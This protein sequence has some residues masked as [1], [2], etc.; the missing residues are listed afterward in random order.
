MYP[1][2]LSNVRYFF[3]VSGTSDISHFYDTSGGQTNCCHVYLLLLIFTYCFILLLF[4]LTALTALIVTYCYLLY[5]GQTHCT[6]SDVSH[7]YLLLSCVIS[8]APAGRFRGFRPLA[9]C[10]GRPPG[11]GYEWEVV[12]LQYAEIAPCTR[13]TRSLRSAN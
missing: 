3:D 1:G 9:S 5:L 2:T 8:P 12:C 4:V 10:L 11:W 6:Y 13:L 7:F